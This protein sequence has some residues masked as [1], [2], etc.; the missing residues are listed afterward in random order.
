MRDSICTT[1]HA[2]CHIYA[3]KWIRPGPD[4]V[5]Q[6]IRSKMDK[7]RTNIKIIIHLCQI[8]RVDA[9][10]SIVLAGDHFEVRDFHLLRDS[11]SNY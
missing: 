3:T 10:L 4:G 11:R 5:S 9:Y 8:N 7:N 6:G 2:H 1:F